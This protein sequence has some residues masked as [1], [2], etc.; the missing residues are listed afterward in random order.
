MAW[1]SD[2]SR[3]NLDCKCSDYLFIYIFWRLQYVF[4]FLYVY[5]CIVFISIRAGF[6]FFLFVFLDVNW[7][8][9][10]KPSIVFWTTSVQPDW[11]VLQRSCRPPPDLLPVLHKTVEPCIVVLFFLAL[12]SITCQNSLCVLFVGNRA[13]PFHQVLWTLISCGCHKPV[14]W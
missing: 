11:L 5:L 7:I 12:V 3:G 10:V 8:H 1:I 4:F 14:S 9:A 2:S 6:F 13:Q